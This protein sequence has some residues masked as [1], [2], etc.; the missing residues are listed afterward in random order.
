MYKSI[1]ATKVMN[2]IVF[3]NKYKILQS[4]NNKR[5]AKHNNNKPNKDDLF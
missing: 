4:N 5:D 1:K 2:H 3:Q